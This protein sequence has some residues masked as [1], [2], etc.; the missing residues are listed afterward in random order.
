MELEFEC[1]DCGEEIEVTFN[2]ESPGGRMRFR[3]NTC[4]E[5]ARTL[6]KD[7]YDRGREEALRDHE[8][9]TDEERRAEG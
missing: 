6:A 2:R 3:V 5:C 4:P 9:P 7:E 1:A 8:C